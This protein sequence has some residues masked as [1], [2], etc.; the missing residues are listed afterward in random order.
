LSNCLNKIINT[1]LTKTINEK[2]WPSVGG[3]T[4]GTCV[5]KTANIKGHASHV[6][7]LSQVILTTTGTNN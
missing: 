2:Y 4:V 3:A 1:F 5:Y 7:L 6:A